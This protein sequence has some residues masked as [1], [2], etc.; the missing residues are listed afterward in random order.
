MC[1]KV[2]QYRMPFCPRCGREWTEILVRMENPILA[3]MWVDS[4]TRPYTQGFL[5]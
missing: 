4:P 2:I 3:N 1:I 5:L